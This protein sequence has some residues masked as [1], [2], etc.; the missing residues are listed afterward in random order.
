VLFALSTAGTFGWLT[1]QARRRRSALPLA[2]VAGGLAVGLVVPPAYNFLTLVWF[3][4]NIPLPFVTEFGMKD[5]LFDALGYVLFIGFGGYLLYTLLLRGLGAKAVYATFAL[6]GMTDLLL[7]LPFLQTGLY[8]YYGDQPLQIGGFPVHWVFLNGLVPTLA[9]SLMYLSTE[10][11]PCS[12]RVAAW[13]VAGCPALAAGL[14]MIPMFP[15]AAA[16]HADV[17]STV[18]IG[19]A[20]L[21]IAGSA[22]ALR[23][24]AT[25]VEG[26]RAGRAVVERETGQRA[27]VALA[28]REALAASGSHA[29][30][31]AGPA[32]HPR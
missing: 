23:F 10:R 5:P 16:L 28:G 22:S 7:E 18:R 3:P 20:V 19:A 15:V 25:V 21:T 27:V 12:R 30:I 11:W 26:E 9:G 29:S 4:S 13:R 2:A 8:R 6:W 32:Y 17:A 31:D 24:V 1:V 14:L